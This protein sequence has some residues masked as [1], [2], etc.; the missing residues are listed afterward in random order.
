MPLMKMILYLSLALLYLLHN[1]LW[2]WNDARFV[3]GVPIG[4]FYHIVYCFVATLLM[5]LL[6]KYAWPAHLETE[7]KKGAE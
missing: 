4:L 5:A 7:D 2:L 3:L 1:D 6:V